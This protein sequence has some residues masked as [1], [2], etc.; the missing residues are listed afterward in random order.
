MIIDNIPIYYQITKNKRQGLNLNS[1]RNNHYQRNN[2]MK[3]EFAKVFQL[4]ISGMDNAV[5][6][7][8]L[9][10][11]YT[12]TRGTA[13]KA[14]LGN[15]GAVLDKFCSDSLV[16]FGLLADDNTEYIKEIIFRDGGIDKQNPHAK[17]E[18]KSMA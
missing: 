8:P 11:V 18:I 16:E 3:K 5:L 9:A 1:Y 7:P 12:I 14:D 10:L 4:L 17:L 13:R 15:I 6:R 2:K